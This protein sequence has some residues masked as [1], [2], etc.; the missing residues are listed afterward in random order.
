MGRSSWRVISTIEQKT[1]GPEKKLQLAKQ[2]REKVEQELRDICNDV[3]ELL[4]KYLIAHAS[5]AE[6]KVFYL[7]MK[8]DYFRYLAEVAAGDAKG[9]V[10]DNSQKAYQDAFDI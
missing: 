6:S 10:V 3:L 8:G 2:Y 4:D 9:S 5:T 7:K 1:E